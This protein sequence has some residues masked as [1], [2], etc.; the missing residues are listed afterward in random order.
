MSTADAASSKLAR[1]RTKA[2]KKMFAAAQFVWTWLSKFSRF[3]TEEN[4][5]VKPGFGCQRGA[6]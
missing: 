6:V 3:Q 5:K 1:Y 2:S 4:E